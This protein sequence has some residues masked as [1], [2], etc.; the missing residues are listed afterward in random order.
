LI[1]PK[2]LERFFYFFNFPQSF[3]LRQYVTLVENAANANLRFIYFW[4]FIVLDE[5]S[6]GVLNFQ[7]LFRFLQKFPQANSYI[8]D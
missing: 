2:I 4:I 6:N 8:E 7:D 1:D 5:V 3:G